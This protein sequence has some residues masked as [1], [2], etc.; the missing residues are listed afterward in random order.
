LEDKGFPLCGDCARR[1]S[2]D[3][4]LIQVVSPEGCF[5][6]R[7]MTAHIPALQRRVLREVRR[8]EFK[9]FTVGL[10]VPS[11]IQEREDQLRSEL[12]IRG[13]ETFKAQ[14]AATIAAFIKKSARKKIDRGHPELSVLVDLNQD[15]ITAAAKSLFVYGRYTKPKGVSQRREYC[16]ECAGRGCDV[17]GDG[18][19]KT[20]SV[21]EI[22]GRRLMKTLRS[23]RVKFT[24]VGSEDIDSSVYAPGRPFI[25]EVK[26]PKLRKIPSKFTVTSGKGALRIMRTKVLKSR[27][28]SIPP[29]V[30]KTRAF[31]KPLSDQIPVLGPSKV[32]RFKG[33]IVNYTNNKGKSTRKRVYSIRVEKKGSALIAE[34]KLDG[35]LPVKRIVS[36]ESAS[37]SLS[38]L[39]GI[40]LVCSGFD[41]LGVQELGPFELEKRN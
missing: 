8:Y 31:V 4:S 2:E 16:D 19:S 30:F 15:V 40:P 36:G 41:I 18:Y 27:P 22:L 13:M 6:C 39:L 7:G 1:Q 26:N 38:E 12:K 17:C 14:A 3:T 10:I 37:P 34:V 20:P 28:I 21:E 29:F 35:G 24:W 25:A 23:P 9:T 32:K 5:I 11:D 33:M